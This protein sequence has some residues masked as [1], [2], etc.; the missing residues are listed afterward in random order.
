MIA[1]HSKPQDLLN[2]AGLLDLVALPCMVV[3]GL[4]AEG[5]HATDA[6]SLIRNL[7]PLAALLALAVVLTVHQ[8]DKGIYFALGAVAEPSLHSASSRSLKL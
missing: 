5:A 2:H 4:R 7:V 1:P 3:I 8:V 6:K